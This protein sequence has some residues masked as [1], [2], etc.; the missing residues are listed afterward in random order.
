[1][2]FT[3]L[4]DFFL[5]FLL[6]EGFTNKVNLLF[7]HFVKVTILQL[8]HLNFNRP[9]LFF[10]FLQEF[11]VTIQKTIT[12]IFQILT[13]VIY[14]NTL[15]LPKTSLNQK[16][17]FKKAMRD[18][19]HCTVVKATRETPTQPPSLLSAVLGALWW[20]VMVWTPNQACEV[21]GKER[22][23]GE[24]M[25]WAEMYGVIRNEKESVKL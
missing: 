7:R 5:S 13:L 16:Q 25:R 20:P 6:N 17:R 23:C 22:A 4:I 15:H 21:R 18:Q 2:I 19:T 10:S 9:K 12:E 3:I 14:I 11:T 8:L 24:T 1:M